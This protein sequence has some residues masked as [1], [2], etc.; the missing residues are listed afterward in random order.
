MFYCSGYKGSGKMG[1]RITI[2][3]DV[4]HGKGRGKKYDT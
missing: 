4:C 2:K 1:D 3:P